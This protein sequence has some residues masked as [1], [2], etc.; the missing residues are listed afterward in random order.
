MNNNDNND[1]NEEIE[2]VYDDDLEETEGLSAVDFDAVHLFATASSFYINHCTKTVM[3]RFETEKLLKTDLVDTSTA[4]DALD[5]WLEHEDDVEISTLKHM[6]IRAKNL[7][8]NGETPLYEQFDADEY[9]LL[10]FADHEGASEEKYERERCECVHEYTKFTEEQK[11]KVD[12]E[13]AVGEFAIFMDKID[14]II[15]NERTRNLVIILDDERYM[16]TGEESSR[17]LSIDERVERVFMSLNP[18]R[19][20]ILQTFLISKFDAVEGILQETHVS[21][22]HKSD[23]S[24]ETKN[25]ILDLMLEG[26]ELPEV[27]EDG[28]FDFG[29]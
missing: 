19:T 1:K 8:E 2:T 22:S 7:R 24:D 10:L 14:G 15:F 9:R 23:E 5:E 29:S 21:I 26:Y 13:A 28:S 17:A 12:P 11:N 6:F 3:A 25:A 18:E 16:N 4:I 27:K 20:E